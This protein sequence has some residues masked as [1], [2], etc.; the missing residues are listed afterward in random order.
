[1]ADTIAIKQAIAREVTEKLRL[2]L[3]GEEERRLV[4]Q[5]T[6]NAEAYQLYL[7]GRYFWNKRTEDGL[8]RGI[9][10][11]QEAVEA[12][13]HYALAHVGLADSL[14]SWVRLALRSF[15]LA[16]RC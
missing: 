15:H 14:T 12:D 6:T 11:F 9:R 10:Y 5:D 1:M 16:K 7:K 13:P 2:R 8:Q 4:Q 3:T